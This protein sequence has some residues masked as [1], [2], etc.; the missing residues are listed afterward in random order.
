MSPDALTDATFLTVQAGAQVVV[1]PEG[2]TPAGST[3]VRGL[4]REARDMLEFTPGL[5]AY[6]AAYVAL[7][8]VIALGAIAVFWLEP[9]WYTCALAFL[10][11]S[12][13]QQA[14]LNCEHE[15]VHC[16]LLPDL[17]LNN[18]VGR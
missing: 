9:A 6:N 3:Q 10:V 15:A 17:R 16:K 7:A 5:V 13:P 14:L 18:F 11:V 12:S 2:R 1:E 4:G 8:W